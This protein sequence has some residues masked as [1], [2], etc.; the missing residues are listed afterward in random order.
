MNYLKNLS[1]SPISYNMS[2]IKSEILP[3]ILVLNS[4]YCG[5]PNYMGSI[6]NKDHYIPHTHKNHELMFMIKGSITQ[7]H[8]RGDARMIPGELYFA[9]MGSYHGSYS[10]TKSETH[11]IVINFTT[12]CFN[13]DNYTGMMVDKILNELTKYSRENYKIQLQNEATDLLNDKFLQID[14]EFSNKK[15]GYQQA[16]VLYLAEIFLVIGRYN[17]RIKVFNQNNFET[18]KDRLIREV[19]LFLQTNYMNSDVTLEKVLQMCPMSR[20]SFFTVFKEM[21]NLTFINYLNNLRLNHAE[22]LLRN[23]Q[24]PVLDISLQ[25]GYNNVSHF[26]HLFKR[27]F[28]VSPSQ[29]RKRNKK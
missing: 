27:E 4:Y 16:M 25:S 7:H 17:K 20:S 22:N 8:P 15:I 3:D 2:M 14:N 19:L 11:F 1:F 9:P 24:V 21:T 28:G 29:I 5:E 12:A 23:T 13:N 10:K 26:N 18:T 6:S